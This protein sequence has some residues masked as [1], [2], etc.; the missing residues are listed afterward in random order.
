MLKNVKILLVEDNP[1]NQR[2]AEAVLESAEAT[3]TTVANG[4][5]CLDALRTQPFD[6]V[7]MDIRMP[8]MDGYET[9]RIIRSELGLTTLPIIAMTAHAA[10]GMAEKCQTAQMDDYVSKPIEHDRL[11]DVIRRLVDVPPSN[12]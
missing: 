9:T 12:F 6:A 5:E 3:V 11:L 4:V 7:L 10:S 1:I 8:H 2:V